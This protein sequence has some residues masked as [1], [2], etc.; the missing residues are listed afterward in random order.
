[1][2]E[3]GNPCPVRTAGSDSE[4]GRAGA[5]AKVQSGEVLWDFRTGL[6]LEIADCAVR[7]RGNRLRSSPPAGKSGK[8]KKG[9][10]EEGERTMNNG[11]PRNYSWSEL[12]LRVFDFVFVKC[13]ACGGRMR[14]LFAINPPAAIKK[15]LD[16]LGLPIFPAVEES[17]FE[18]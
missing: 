16:C 2:A 4:T 7:F 10:D 18:F 12:M 14:I 1:M 8:R 5:A 15:I 13:P 17:L 11:H 6:A 9:R 3:R